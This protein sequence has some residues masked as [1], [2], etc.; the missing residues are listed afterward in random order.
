[1]AV[2][3][4]S[5]SSA[6]DMQAEPPG[7][8][9]VGDGT[10]ETLRSIDLFASLSED[11]LIRLVLASKR[12]TWKAGTRIISHTEKSDDYYVII[13]GSVRVYQVTETGEE[14]SFAI[15]GPGEGFGEIALLTQAPRSASVAAV[16]DSDLFVIPRDALLR[17]VF[18]NAEA[19]LQFARVLAERLTRGNIHLVE[20]ANTER[21]YRQF[22]SEHLRPEEPRLPGDSVPVLKLHEEIMALAASTDS[23]LVQ[24]EPGTEIWDAASLIH[25]SGPVRHGILLSLDVKTLALPPHAYVDP[26]ITP[27][28][29]DMAQNSMLYGRKINALSFAPDAR[30]GLLQMAAAGTLIIEHLEYLTPEV[31]K[32]LARC[33]TEKSFTPV[34]TTQHLALNARILS[35]TN[36]DLQAMVEAGTFDRGL[37]ELLAQKTVVVPPLRKRKKD[38][39]AILESLIQQTRSQTDKAVRGISGEAYKALMAYG[40]PGNRDELITVLRRAISISRGEELQLEDLF[41]G[42]PPVTGRI[43]YN[44]LKLAPVQRVFSSAVLRRTLQLGIAGFI[45]AIIVSGLAGSQQAEANSTIVLTWGLWEPAL[46]ISAFF[47]ARLWCSVCPIG[48]ASS[49]LGRTVGLRR[50]V[51]QF[52]R[53]YGIY[54]SAAG[55]ALIFWSESASGMIRSPRATSLLILSVV[56]GA[57]SVGLYYRRRAWCRFL[58]PLGGMVGL[59]SSCSIIEMRSNYNIC[60]NDCKTHACYAGEGAYEGCPMYEG[61][62]SLSSNLNC[63]LCGKC[64][65]ACPNKSPVLNLR[66]PAH[67][68][69]TAKN[70]EKGLM[71]LGLTLVATQLFR[72]FEMAGVFGLHTDIPPG[73]WKTSIPLFLGCLA[74]TYACFRYLAARTFA[75][76]NAEPGRALGLFIYGLIPLAV[77]FEV[78]FHMGRL[79]TMGGSLLH[80]LGRQL[81]GPAALPTL[82]ASGAAVAFFQVLLMLLGALASRGVFI[83]LLRGGRTGENPGPAGLRTIWP[84]LALTGGYIIFFLRAAA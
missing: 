42:P 69:W 64:I 51:P 74:A 28:M 16:S 4:D 58:C 49:F 11:L 62:F 17:V 35:T 19:A 84:L 66:L 77:A 60:N 24:G 10:E 9:T 61:P 71:V 72:G 18:S 5:P 67:E 2:S 37:F 80:V 48:A 76:E 41:I 33:I 25:R 32:K 50:K 15:L 29:L 7:C 27:Y 47:A 22:I 46:V 78:A 81:H 59:L 45:A 68:L 30:P 3:S 56:L 40:W 53:E 52:L 73:W 83:K 6:S 12:L 14:V 82:A 39:R 55:L 57:V 20:V 31:Q 70:P 65:S 23:V 26:E 21:A 43:A 44:L 34:G 1:M 8:P 75:E 38:I 79:L 36:A 63:I 54:I 13:S